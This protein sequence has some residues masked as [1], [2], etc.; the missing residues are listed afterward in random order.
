M[1]SRPPLPVARENV[2]SRRSLTIL[3]V[4]DHEDTIVHL[5]RYLTAEGHTVLV[6]RNSDQALGILREADPDLLLCDI[7]LPDGD[8]WNLMAHLGEDRPAHCVA[9]SVRG[10]PDDLLRSQ[11]AGFKHHLTKPFLPEDLDAVLR[12]M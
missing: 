11:A 7:L 6:A 12:R 8:G 5:S 9:M 2:V 10:E 3:I 1:D 4:E